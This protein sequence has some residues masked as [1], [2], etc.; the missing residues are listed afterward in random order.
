MNRLESFHQLGYLHLDLKPDNIL[1]K[2]PDYSIW[3]SSSV[4]YLIDFGI[5]KKFV[6]DDG[7]HIK[8]A[9]SRVPF[10]GNVVFASRNAF[11]E[12]GK[13]SQKVKK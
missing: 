13:F 4:L 8:E 7:S 3:E 6:Q 1:I 11:N 9:T 12:K 10:V 2:S 5:S